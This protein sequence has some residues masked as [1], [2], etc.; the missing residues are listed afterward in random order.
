MQLMRILGRSLLDGFWRLAGPMVAEDGDYCPLA[1]SPTS[2]PAHASNC[3]T[4][5]GNQIFRR[6]LQL[7]ESGRI[8][9]ARLHLQPL[10][11]AARPADGVRLMSAALLA[12]QGNAR[13][14]RAELDHLLQEY[15]D[16][17]RLWF[18]AGQLAE[19]CQQVEQAIA[20]YRNGMKCRGQSPCWCAER[21]AAVYL[22][23]NDLP[24]ARDALR[25]LAEAL[26]HEFNVR[27]ELA[28]VQV[29]LGDYP[30]AVENFQDAI[31]IESDD[32]QIHGD[33]AAALEAN[34][35][36]EEALQAYQRVLDERPQFADVQLKAAKVCGRLNRL[37]EALVHVKC[38]LETNPRYLEAIV[39]QGLLLTELDQRTAALASFHRAIDVNDQYVSAYVA[40][41][42]TLQCLGQDQQAAETMDLA[43]KIAPGSEQIYA[44]LSQVGLE[45]AL[46]D[47]QPAAQ[48]SPDCQMFLSTAPS[49]FSG[50]QHNAGQAEYQPQ[51]DPHAGP[52]DE[53]QTIADQDWPQDFQHD[54]PLPEPLDGDDSLLDEDELRALREAVAEIVSPQD[55]QGAPETDTA[56]A[57]QPPIDHDILL[58]RQLEAHRQAVE[59]C[60]QYADLRYRYGLLLASLGRSDE[61][62][63]QYRAAVAINPRYV[64]ALIR[65]ALAAWQ[66]DRLEQSQT[67]LQRLWQLAP[68]EFRSHYGF[69]VAWSDRGLWPLTMQT[70]RSRATADSAEA[71]Y[72]AGRTALMNL[73]TSDG[74]RQ[75]W[76]AS[77]QLVDL[78]ERGLL[79]VRLP[80]SD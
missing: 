8:E 19:R 55:G 4:H 77:L 53:H 74:R 27:A 64:E 72:S 69:G 78:R 42:W 30:R 51:S 22:M 40:L 47:P 49:R 11:D 75:T 52:A 80:S 29:L 50:T 1:A 62:L 71:I 7:M 10:L 17:G 31:L 34:Q 25:W 39:Y 60:P 32:W 58:R 12:D 44:R 18:M 9:A 59:Q 57:C 5:A 67:A 45:A 13:A 14:A 61:A 16:D 15:D 76:M 48:P 24:R 70:V 3:L 21:L 66:T 26:P 73:G 33:L 38:A 37:E 28:S 65:L 36:W 6:S 79:P 2:S 41:A 68:E 56:G 46:D 43:C 54:Q 63:E 20:C 23:S 35:Q